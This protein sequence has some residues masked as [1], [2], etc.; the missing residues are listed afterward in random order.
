MVDPPCSRQFPRLG[1]KKETISSSWRQG[2]SPTITL[3]KAFVFCILYVVFWILYFLRFIIRIICFVFLYFEFVFCILIPAKDPSQPSPSTLPNF[4]PHQTR[5]PA[6]LKKAPLDF[7]KTPNYRL[8]PETFETKLN[9]IKIQL[10]MTWK[11]P[12]NDLTATWPWP[13]HDLTYDMTW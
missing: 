9:M 3:Y 1:R 7:W 12:D 2:P 4:S 11:L 10:N 13:D 6:S 8:T 5:A